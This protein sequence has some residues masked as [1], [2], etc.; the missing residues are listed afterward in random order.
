MAKGS[1]LGRSVG[2]REREAGSSEDDSSQSL[3]AHLP[4]RALASSKED[5]ELPSIG[6][7]DRWCAMEEPIRAP[8]GDGRA[9]LGLS[10]SVR[11]GLVV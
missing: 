5:W 7:C 8:K 11:M 4:E 2:E 6:S 1:I 9:E 10:S 3:R